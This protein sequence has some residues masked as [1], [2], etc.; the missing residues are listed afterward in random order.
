MSRRKRIETIISVAL[1][2]LLAIART[3]GAA[4]AYDST[5][6]IYDGDDNGATLGLK[7]NAS[8][9]YMIQAWLQPADQSDA[10]DLPI[11]VTPPIL[12]LAAGQ[13]SVLR[14]YY[15]GHGLPKDKESL[16]WINVQEIPPKP[17]ESNVLQIAVRTRMKLFYR[18][19]GLDVSMPQAVKALQWSEQNGYLV[20]RNPSVLHVTF[21]KVVFAS[22][23]TPKILSHM[24]SPGATERVARVPGAGGASFHAVYINDYGGSSSTKT[25]T[26]K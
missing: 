14:F 17:K 8:V 23:K 24:V 22:G 4:V 15:S 20:V 25:I 3:A 12:K 13:H 11:V 9:P 1:F 19:S 10:P 2:C 21:F 5:R 6:V 18:P 7:N 26:L 16:F